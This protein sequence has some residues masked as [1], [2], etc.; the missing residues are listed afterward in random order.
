MELSRWNH[1]RNSSSVSIWAKKKRTIYMEINP[2]SN[3]C[4]KVSIKLSLKSRI[5]AHND[6]GL[7]KWPDIYQCSTCFAA[8]W[9]HSNKKK[10]RIECEK[11][12]AN[13]WQ[14]AAK[15]EKQQQATDRTRIFFLI[16]LNVNFAYKRLFWKKKTDSFE[17]R[18]KKNQ[19]MAFFI[20]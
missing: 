7:M 9:M 19:C 17:Y 5:I 13:G 18:A 3:K 12:E 15:Y 8:C 11:S 14:Q 10:F 16:A 1:K 4:K 2:K 6:V 20:F